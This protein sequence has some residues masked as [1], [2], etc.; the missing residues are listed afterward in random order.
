MSRALELGTAGE[1]LVCADLLMQ[2]YRASRSSRGLPYD[3]VLD[4]EGRLLRVAVKATLAAKERPSRMG[5]R[6]CYQ[7]N[8]TRSRSFVGGKNGARRYTSTEA[9][10]IALVALDVRLVAYFTIRESVTIQHFDSPAHPAGT[11]KFGP[12][13]VRRKQFEDFPLIRALTLVPS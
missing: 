4:V 6:P 10:L 11:N 3:I 13:S 12:K 2:G 9:D 1:H 8:I 7:F 5:S